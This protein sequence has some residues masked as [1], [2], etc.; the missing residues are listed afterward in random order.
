[1]ACSKSGKSSYRNL[2]GTGFGLIPDLLHGVGAE[3]RPQICRTI[4]VVFFLYIKN[5]IYHN[6]KNKAEET[7]I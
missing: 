5:F 4:F 2:A 6:G 1:M 3:I 7:Y